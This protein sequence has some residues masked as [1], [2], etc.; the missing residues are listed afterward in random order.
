MNEQPLPGLA[1]ASLFMA[2]VTAILAAVFAW[3][4]SRVTWRR[5]GEGRHWMRFAWVV[6]LTYGLTVAT[7]F[8]PI[9]ILW[10]VWVQLGLFSWAAGEMWTRNV[11]FTEAQR[12]PLPC[13]CPHHKPHD[14]DQSL[15]D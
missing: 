12:N 8:L 7:Y 5:T 11:L 15:H 1:L 10:L 3:R 9:P 13:P 14:E 6:C 4:Y 2:G